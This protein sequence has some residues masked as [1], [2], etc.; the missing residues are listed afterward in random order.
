MRVQIRAGGMVLFLVIGAMQLAA[1]AVLDRSELEELRHKIEEQANQIR[2]LEE[3]LSR[4]ERLLAKEQSASGEGQ[5]TGGIPASR[6]EPVVSPAV[7]SAAT[8]KSVPAVPAPPQSSVE[9]SSKGVRFEG[10]LQAWYLAGDGGV[11]DT[12]RIR[13][14]EM[15]LSSQITPRV[16]WVLKIDPSKSMSINSGGVNQASRM[17]QDAFITLQSSKNTSIDIGQYKVPLGLE[18][19]Q[20][21]EALDTVERALFASDRTRGGSLGDVRDLGVTLRGP[22][23]HFAN[24]QLGIFNGVGENQ[25][26]TDRNDRKAY[27]GRLFGHPV[28]G[29]QLGISAARSD[30]SRTDMTR[31]DRWGSEALFKRGRLTLK[32]ELMNG[33]DGDTHRRGYYGHVGYLLRPW[34]EPVFRFDV[35]DPDTAA[36]NQPSNVVERDFVGGFNYFITE[37]HLKLQF[38]SLLSGIGLA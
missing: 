9:G 19:L 3:R 28:S 27:A 33:V 10:L 21:S 8:I 25:N 15:K 16:R 23:S 29:L 12:F 31:R 2:Q 5:A 6:V 36:D 20:G 22:L 38:N 26:D 34:L 30:G 37:N 1:A 4:Q 35:W 7:V 18:G 32:T 24:Y 17:L 11:N 13:R 14:T